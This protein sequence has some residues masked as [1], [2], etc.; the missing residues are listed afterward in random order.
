MTAKLYKALSAVVGNFRWPSR[1][2]KHNNSRERSSSFLLVSCCYCF[3]ALCAWFNIVWQ[4]LRSSSLFWGWF[5]SCLHSAAKHCCCCCL[6]CCC[7][8]RCASLAVLIGG[9]RGLRRGSRVVS[10]E[11]YKQTYENVVWEN[12]KTDRCRYIHIY[13]YMFNLC[14]YACVVCVYTLSQFLRPCFPPRVTLAKCFSN[15]TLSRSYFSL[16]PAHTHTV[17]SFLTT[18]TDA[19]APSHQPCIC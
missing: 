19:P 4:N 15:P 7:T 9:V 2:G 14:M 1:T 16:C 11:W 12:A 17:A 6:C 13:V 10:I 5:E 3:S 18:I 8:E